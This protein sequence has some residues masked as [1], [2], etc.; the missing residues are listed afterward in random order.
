MSLTVSM[1]AESSLT[2]LLKYE[3]TD[4][5]VLSA[6]LASTR[7]LMSKRDLS[8]TKDLLKRC[9]DTLENMRIRKRDSVRLEITERLERL[10]R[11]AHERRVLEAT[12]LKSP[13]SPPP[14]SKEE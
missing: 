12:A 8:N 3:N 1:F 2:Q 14:S 11:V 7:A 5:C 13:P 10:R 9:K 4:P 6:S